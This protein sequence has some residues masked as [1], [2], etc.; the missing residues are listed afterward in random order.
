MQGRPGFRRVLL[1]LAQA[2]HEKN[3][4]V[5][6]SADSVMGVIDQSEGFAGK[7]GSLRP[8]L[9]DSMVVSA[10][11]LYDAEHGGF[12]SAPKFPHPSA[13][14]L[15]MQRYTENH[16][17]KLLEIV[18]GTLEKMAKGGIYDQLAGGFHRYSVDEHWIVPHFEKMAYDNSELLRN[19]VH[20]YQAFGDE[21]F[22]RV[23]RDIMRWM[24]EWLS[25]RERGGF[26]ASQ[27]ADY[28]LDDDGD[29][30][31]W[32][33]DE[34]AEVLEG[35]ELELAKEYFDV[36]EIGDMHHNVAKNVLHVKN[37]IGVVARK[38]GFGAEAAA[39]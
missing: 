13:L 6:E 1:A 31:T 34:V 7:S 35:E 12:G 22:A 5:L 23:A 33:V 11:K 18:S 25:D 15:L 29:Y 38:L 21:E 28:S 30:F 24:D 36:G 20:G 32:T 16:D 27:D 4:E 2:F 39:A 8:E 19:Y 26:Y 9:I 3:A 17:A 10:M 14:D 37:G